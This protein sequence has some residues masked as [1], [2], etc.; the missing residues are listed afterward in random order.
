VKVDVITGQAFGQFQYFASA[1]T[2]PLSL[3]EVEMSQQNVEKRLVGV[4]F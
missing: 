1:T 4:L 3:V 2:L